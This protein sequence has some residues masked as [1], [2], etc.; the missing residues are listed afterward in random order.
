MPDG[1]IILYQSEDGLARVQLR[2][3][4]GSVWLTQ[5]EIAELFDTSKQNVSLHLKNLLSE[6]ELDEAAVVKESLIT[7]ADGKAYSTRLLSGAGRVS[8]EKMERVVGERY[9]AFDAN[10]K[11]AELAASESEYEAELRALESAAA[12]RKP[13]PRASD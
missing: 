13:K 10:R 8:H 12:A 2:A 11:G 5:T 6:G 4:D 1:E 7:A 3:F 9:A